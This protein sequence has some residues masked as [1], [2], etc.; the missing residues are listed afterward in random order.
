MLVVRAILI[1]K[2]L[3]S[4]KLKQ[5]T[6]IMCVDVCSL[7]TCVFVSVSAHMSVSA[8]VSVSTHVSVSARV[9]VSA[10]VHV[11]TCECLFNYYTHIILSISRCF[12]D[13]SSKQGC[14]V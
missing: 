12:K 4:N 3:R 11:C 1:G 10:H 7:C 6:I 2:M 9:S 14:H 8:H 5:P 13:V